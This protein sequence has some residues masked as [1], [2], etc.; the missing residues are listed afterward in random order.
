M[1][2]YVIRASNA[3]LHEN[4][5]DLLSAMFD[6]STLRGLLQSGRAAKGLA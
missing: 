5:W 1:S 4:R 2:F 3:L 6:F